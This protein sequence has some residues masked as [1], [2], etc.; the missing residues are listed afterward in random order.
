MNRVFTLWVLRTVLL[1]CWLTLTT[2]R[3]QAGG[4]ADF[5]ML[6]RVEGR[7]LEGQ[8][9]KWTD[10]QMFLLGRDGQLHE[11]AP[12]DAEQSRKTGPAFRAYTMGEMRTLL[13][14]D[15]DNRFE[16][17]TTNHFVVVHPRGQW[18]AWADRLESLY[19][20]FTHYMQVRGFRIEQPKV[21]LVAVVFRTQGDYYSHAAAAGSPLTPGT[22]G[23]YDPKS[24]RIYLFDASQS[25][26]DDWSVNAETIIHEATHQTAFNVGVHRRFAEQPRWLVEGLAMMFEA[27]GVW[28]ARS[29]YTRSDRINRDRL[30]DFRYCLPK[31]PDGAIVALV[32]TDDLF[33]TSPGFAYAEAWALSFFLCETRPQEYSRYLE[34]V[35]ARQPFHEYPAKE[36]LADFVRIFGNDVELLDAQFRRFM[37]ELE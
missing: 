24:N 10:S 12:E 8:P 27:P 7:L 16:I 11:F 15:F 35:A 13:H 34:I 37:A 2:V 26:G 9:L 3:L 32:A 33:R 22:L 25:S 5:M 36:R 4:P 21:P 30:D 31:R 18:S 28:D 14:E 1:T 6:T 17:S 29:T 20:S 19:R 23:H